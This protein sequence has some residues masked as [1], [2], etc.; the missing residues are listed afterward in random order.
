MSMTGGAASSSSSAPAPLQ[1]GFARFLRLD[2]ESSRHF[3][4]V[5]Q[6]FAHARHQH[7]G[8]H[9]GY[10]PYYV[11]EGAV[12]VGSGSPQQTRQH[13]YTYAISAGARL[14]DCGDKSLGVN[15][16]TVCMLRP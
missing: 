16:A 11:S 8:A 1:H 3:Q 15:V 7:H 9:A 5:V 14:L 4:A 2:A 12:H 6:E 10:L 13:G